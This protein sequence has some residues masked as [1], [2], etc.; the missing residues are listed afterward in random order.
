MAGRHA[1]RGM[2]TA[3]LGLIVLQTVSTQ[4]GSGRV[5]GL[6]YDIDRLLQRA[7]DPSVPAIPNLAKGGRWGSGVTGSIGAD[8]TV[9]SPDTPYTRPGAA[10]AP[11]SYPTE[12]GGAGGAAYGI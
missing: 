3:W 11:A 1:V 6:F 10:P 7:L 4:G 8:P 2:V 9:T 12:T 5:S